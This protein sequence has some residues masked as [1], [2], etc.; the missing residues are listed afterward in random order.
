MTKNKQSIN[1]PPSV[2][3]GYADI[4]IELVAPNFILNTHVD[5]YGEF[6]AREM[7]ISLQKNL[8]GQTLCNC[9]LHEI[10]HSIVYGSGLNQANGPLKDEDAEELTV[11]Q[12]T[13]YLMGVF[14]DNVWLLDFIK[15]NMNDT[16]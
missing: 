15:Q 1:L 7:T 2:K 8:D 16:H 11:N 6:R 13:N 12:I 3:V 9:L 10:C 4:K 14:R 5:A